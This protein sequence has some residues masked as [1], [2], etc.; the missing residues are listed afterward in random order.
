MI[1]QYNSNQFIFPSSLAKLNIII[2][3]SNFYLNG[4]QLF[5]E[6]FNY[7]N[8]LQPYA[9]YNSTPQLGLNVY[10]FCLSPTEFQPTG[11][12]NMSRISFIG[13]K[14]K[15]NKKHDDSFINNIIGKEISPDTNDEYKL[16]FQTRNYNVL[17]II[18]GIG[19]TAYTYN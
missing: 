7:F 2:S 5:S 19:A 6:T 12:C 3:A 11:S 9:Y 14:L 13:L 16:I 17:R 4:T 15:I 10:S 8:F 1:I 18:G